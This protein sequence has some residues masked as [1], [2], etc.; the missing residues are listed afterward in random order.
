MPLYYNWEVREEFATYTNP[1]LL[2]QPLSCSVAPS[3]L[4]PTDTQPT[5]MPSESP[6]V[7][8]TTTATEAPFYREAAFIVGMVILGVVLMF[9]ACAIFLCCVRPRGNAGYKVTEL[10]ALETMPLT[11][12]MTTPMTTPTRS[13]LKHAKPEQEHATVTWTPGD[14][15][16]VSTQSFLQHLLKTEKDEREIQP[17][18]EP[19]F[20]ECRSDVLTI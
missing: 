19:G 7:T 13:G 5:T 6:T 2:F 12:P 8:S 9:T 10:H 4:P 11:T 18:F 1:L 14:P 20:S 16:W 3:M 15:T 17:G